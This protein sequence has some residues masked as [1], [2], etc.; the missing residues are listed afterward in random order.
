MHVCESEIIVLTKSHNKKEAEC[1][2]SRVALLPYNLEITSW[3]WFG[4]GTALGG[5]KQ[6]VVTIAPNNLITSVWRMTPVSPSAPVS[7]FKPHPSTAKWNNPDMLVLAWHHAAT[8]FLW[9]QNQHTNQCTNLK[10]KDFT[11]VS[12][13]WGTWLYMD[14][15]TPFFWLLWKQKLSVTNTILLTISG[16]SCESR[17][18]LML[19]MDRKMSL[20]SFAVSS[21]SAIIST[22]E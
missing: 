22:I 19:Y 3:W 10:D 11:S 7:H 15:H 4:N 8:S 16:V 9:T 12:V 18:L 13:K 21:F 2:K 1:I 14:S 20:H 5:A 17:G 6:T